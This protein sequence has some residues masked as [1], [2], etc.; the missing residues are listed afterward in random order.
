MAVTRRT[1]HRPRSRPG[2]ARVAAAVT[3]AAA[4]AVLFSAEA[5]T[6]KQPPAP[7]KQIPEVAQYVE[8][9]PTAAGPAAPAVKPPKDIP[10]IAQY[11]E[12]VPTAAGP[13]APTIGKRT[14]RPLSP[15]VRAQ[16]GREGGVLEAKL[17]EV[18]T[19]SRYG[20]PGGSRRTDLPDS[21]SPSLTR[22]P[23]ALGS[24]AT[25]AGEPRMLVLLAALAAITFGLVG[26][27]LT[28]IG[29]AFGT[30]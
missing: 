9:I 1:L 28:R 18:A 20:A 27:A 24:A 6:A 29:R 7:P 3:G 8:D 16:V 19:S 21:T 10:E 12:D 13:S 26:I 14:S 2:S 22:I 5:W 11:V 30:R 17:K 4:A 23:E 25:S 15:R